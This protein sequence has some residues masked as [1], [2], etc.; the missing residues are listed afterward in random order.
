M[1]GRYAIRAA[2]FALAATA[3]LLLVG[4][5]SSA[6][7]STR[8]SRLIAVDERVA[9]PA[10]RGDF[11]DGPGSFELSQQRGKV[12]IINFWA[13]YCPPCRAEARELEAVRAGTRA[14]GVEF[15]GINVRDQPD[16]AMAYIADVKPSYQSLYDPASEL[17]LDFDVPPNSIPATLLVDR[18][19]RLAAV[20]R[21]AITRDLLEPVIRDL[22]AE[23]T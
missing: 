2:R 19:G 22:L 7:G 6:A 21:G 15:L 13:S 14:D 10:L 4:G 5:C 16:P 18:K 12:V 3:A 23:Q 17:A 20:F 11:M 9:A 8:G 1:K